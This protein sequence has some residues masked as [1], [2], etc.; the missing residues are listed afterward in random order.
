MTGLELGGILVIVAVIVAFVLWLAVGQLRMLARRSERAET[1]D[2]RE[3]RRLLADLPPGTMFGVGHAEP[4]SGAYAR[5]GQELAAG[6]EP[7]QARIPHVGVVVRPS[8]GLR[9]AFI[10]PRGRADRSEPVSGHVRASFRQFLEGGPT[11]RG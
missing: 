4:W 6:M 3:L 2:E 5:I 7:P 11:Y 8:Y 10:W 9:P 1:P